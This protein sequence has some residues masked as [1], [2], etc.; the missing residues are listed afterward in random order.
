MRILP[1]FVAAL[2]MLLPIANPVSFASIENSFDYIS[3]SDVNGIN[4]T[5]VTEIQETCIDAGDGILIVNATCPTCVSDLEYSIDDGVSWQPS[6]VFSGLL[7]DVI[8]EILIRDSGDHT[9]MLNVFGSVGGAPPC[10]DIAIVNID[11]TPES[12]AGQNDGAITVNA[13]CTDCI[14]SIQYSID[15]GLTFQSSSTFNNLT[16]GTYMVYIEDTQ[17]VDCF[18]SEEIVVNINSCDIVIDFLD[19]MGASCGETSDGV[20]TIFATCASCPGGSSDIE[21]SWGGY[22]WQ[23]SNVI[24]GLPPEFWTFYVRDANDVSCQASENALIGTGPPCCD[25]AISSVDVVDATCGGGT[26]G[27]I[28]IFASCSDCIGDIEY[29][30]NGVFQAS[31]IFNN[32]GPGSYSVFARDSGDQD[33]SDAFFT[34]I[35]PG[36]PPTAMCADVTIQ[37]DEFGAAN[38]VAL[39]LENGSTDDC[40]DPA[41]FIFS[42]DESTL[43]CEGI[44]S[45]QTFVSDNTWLMSTQVEPGG[46]AGGLFMGAMALP[47][48]STFSVVPTY[49]ANPA[50]ALLNAESIYAGSDITFFKKTF[51]L[52]ATGD[53]DLVIESNMARQG[54]IYIN[55]QYICREEDWDVANFT[56]STYHKIKIDQTGSIVNG[57]NGGQEYDNVNMALPTDL[58]V[59][60]INELIFV[61][62]NPADPNI[63]GGFSAIVSIS[64]DVATSPVVLTVTDD[65]GNDG[66]CISNVTL[67][68][69]IAPEFVGTLPP[70]SITITCLKDLPLL[71]SVVATD[72]CDANPTI[73]Y[74]QSEINYTINNQSIFRTWTAVD[75]SLNSTVYVQAIVV[76]DGGVVCDDN[77]DFITTWETTSANESITIPI[78]PDFVYNYTVD[79]GDG[80]IEA[81]NSSSTTHVYASAGIYQVE[82]SGVFPAIHLLDNANN[83][84]KLKSLEQWGN[85]EWHS[86]YGAFSEAWDMDYNATDVPNLINTTSLERAFL[87]CSDLNGDLSDWNTSAITNMRSTFNGCATFES[88]IGN[89]DVSNVTTMNSCFKSAFSFNQNLNSWNTSSLT[90]IYKMFDG[91]AAFNGDISSWDVSNVQTMIAVFKD[92]ISFNKDISTWDVSN[93]TDVSQMFQ[94][95]ESFNHDLAAWDMTKVTRARRMLDFCNMDLNNYDAT[96]IGWAAQNLQPIDNS[97]PYGSPPSYISELGVKSLKYCAGDDARDILETKG[98]MAAGDAKDVSCFVDCQCNPDISPLIPNTAGGLHVANLKCD[99]G[100]FTH[101]CDNLGRLLLSIDSGSASSIAASDVQI[102]I[103]PGTNYYEQFCA[104]SGGTEDGSCF[105]TQDDGAIVLCRTWDVNSTVIDASIRYY[106]DDSDIQIINQGIT[107]LGMT[108]TTSPEQLW[109]YKV[110]GG[111]GHQKPEDLNA[112]DIDIIDNDG[113][114]VPSNNNWVLGD[115]GL[116]DYFA[117]YTVSSFSGGGG[118]GAEDG[119]SPVCP[120][121]VGN[122]SGTTILTAPGNADI[123]VEI[124]GGVAPYT[125]TLDDGTVIANY[126]SGD[127]ISVFVSQTTGFQLAQ[128]SDSAACPQSKLEGN[129]IIY[130]SGDDQSS[131]EALCQDLSVSLDEFAIANVT[132]LDVDAGSFDDDTGIAIYDLDQNILSCDDGSAVTLTLTVTDFQGNS[133]SC[134]S[135]VTI[136][137]PLNACCPATRDIPYPPSDQKTYQADLLITSDGRIRKVDGTT[138]ILFQAGQEVDLNEGFEVE[139]GAMFE[140]L[141]DP[142]G[143]N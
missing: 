67:E 53:V 15:D 49:Q 108:G 73:E 39:D 124:I 57:F 136:A 26:D 100:E 31:N 114:N 10:C 1:F 65:E 115:T 118:G 113:S 110:I 81:G 134:I 83:A 63:V 87:N 19:V 16:A 27:S 80:I 69:L 129:A 90:D 33:C 143:N 46:A 20:V 66:T 13:S 107:S 138:D 131:P 116:G 102:N 140:A 47:D 123:S 139:E 64:E 127:L 21:Y 14:G 30:V 89:W 25:V 93:V 128:I 3:E 8:H 94:G 6:P 29:G 78:N 2:A 11:V 62:S 132:S 59:Q 111:G 34:S 122:I 99:D 44:T 61:L 119:G 41:N 86:M 79:W 92:A 48:A 40:T 55:G 7:G 28:T 84:K 38:I 103:N 68:D 120:A 105:I 74:Q 37:I 60:G 18:A 95:A 104:N 137:D 126:N 130:L 121:I 71:P 75:H 96:L 135:E 12:G 85:I 141:I 24:T 50:E 125:V 142:C 22:F 76:D 70:A 9:C 45:T 101:Y 109:F 58:F 4:F 23:S 36:N 98:W 117:E 54:E 35:E 112:T 133:S 32:L 77:F 52:N 91:A 97:P 17:D 106:F 82:I 72:N 42:V 43:G 5:G 56:G 51:N 88:D